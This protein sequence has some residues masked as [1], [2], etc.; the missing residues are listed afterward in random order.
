[1]GQG[2]EPAESEVTLRTGTKLAIRVFGSLAKAAAEP[3][4]RWIA[5]HGYLDNSATFDALCPK[6]LAQ[7]ASAIVCVDLAGH[8]RSDKRP[9]YH[10]LDYA[11][12]TIFLA[13][14][15]QWDRYSLLAHSLG[16]SVSQVVAATVPDRVVRLV[17]IEA[18]GFMSQH[19][20]QAVDNLRLAV[21][22]PPKGSNLQTYASLEAAAQ[23]RAKMNLVG[24]LPIEA[25][26]ILCSRGTKPAPSGSG[27]VWAS[28][29][30][31]L[32]P[33]RFRIEEAT[34]QYM[35]SQIKCP[36]LLLYSQD[37]FL[38]YYN[39][40]VL[41]L[42]TFSF[43]WCVVIGAVYNVWKTAHSM[44]TFGAPPRKDTALFKLRMAYGVLRRW[45]KASTAKLICLPDGGH[46][47]HLTR[48]DDVA[49]AIMLWHSGAGQGKDEGQGKIKGA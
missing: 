16:G 49:K 36:M 26:R 46:H 19:P 9:P 20:D 7:G 21:T 3:S 14:A 45:M 8:G 41:G 10:A 5:L 37:G 28:D 44:I 29:P 11:A 33:S 31:L 38:R 48:A 17:S 18:L 42:R 32:A 35:I 24:S 2:S 15:L 40:S 34:M 4:T 39:L 23:R 12:D 43:P 6:L 47:P 1:M 25:A 22:T 13:E 27:L 30:E